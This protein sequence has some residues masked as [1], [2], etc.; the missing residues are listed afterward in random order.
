[1][2]LIEHENKGLHE[3]YKLFKRS[4]NLYEVH[5]I[6]S[7]SIQLWKDIKSHKRIKLNEII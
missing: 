6:H 2:T 1:M 7:N 3:E 4:D 5:L